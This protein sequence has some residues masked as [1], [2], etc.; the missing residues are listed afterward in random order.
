M[1]PGITVTASRA[2]ELEVPLR[3]RRD[4]WRMFTKAETTRA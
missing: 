1:K 3:A 4:V 2:D